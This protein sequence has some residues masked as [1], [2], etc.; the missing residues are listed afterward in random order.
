M[1]RWRSHTNYLAG[2]VYGDGTLYYYDKNREH[3]ILIYDNSYEFLKRIGEE[4]KRILKVR[5]TIVK[6][7]KTKNYYRL[8]FTNAE[9]YKRIEKLLEER[10]KRLTKNFVRGILDAEGTIYTD[11]K[12]RI[13]LEIAMND[14]QLIEKIQK[15]LL[16]KGIRATV[17]RHNDKR[18][19]RSIIYKVRIRG[20][21]NVDKAIELLDPKHPK[22][23]DKYKE[24]RQMKRN[25]L[26]LF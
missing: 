3:F 22:I 14:R 17:T 25:G 15:W 1:C 7:S 19:N 4:T 24:L 21:D 8:Q 26:R 18:R 23:V 20:W 6:P 9:L 11:K 12:G 13:S 16:Q 5:Y 10:P 2:L